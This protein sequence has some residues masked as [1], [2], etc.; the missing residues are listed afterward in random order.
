VRGDL[1][2]IGPM[3]RSAA[4]LAL[5]LGVVAGPDEWADGIG[6]KLALPPPRHDKLAEFRVM[7]IDVH[8]LCLTAA[9]V[10]GALNGLADRLAKL[11]VSVVRKSAKM[12][13]LAL[14]SRV[15]R[16]LLSASFSADLP[17]E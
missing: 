12:P 6:Y 11:G 4:D 8:P 13:D 3:A 7:V 10:A 1:A 5:Q 14:T 17:P 16:Q 15:Y 9:D 2:V